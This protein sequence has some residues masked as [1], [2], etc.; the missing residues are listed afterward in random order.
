[1][2][3]AARIT[4]GDETW[5]LHHDGGIERPNR[6][7]PNAAT[8]RVA[9]AET[10]N[11]FGHC[12]RR[13]SLSE[14]LADPAGIPWHHKNGSQRTFVFDVDHGSNRMWGNPRHRIA[15]L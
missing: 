14:I 4:R 13:W 5:Y 7:A 11:N 15:A 6:V 1:M 9:G 3:R 10:L 2:A 12:V 8:W